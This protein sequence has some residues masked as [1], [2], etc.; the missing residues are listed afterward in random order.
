MLIP[1]SII[2][3]IGVIYGWSTISSDKISNGICDENNTILMCPQCDKKCDFWYLKETCTSSKFNYVIDN[4]YTVFYALFM[5][6]W[7]EFFVFLFKL[8]FSLTKTTLHGD[9]VERVITVNKLV[10]RLLI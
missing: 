6:I 4:N 9:P 7:G 5:S 3:I 10:L 1:A 8:S 2:G